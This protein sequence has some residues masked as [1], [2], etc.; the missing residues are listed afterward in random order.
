MRELNALQLQ[1]THANRKSPSKSR[2][3]LHQ[4]D[5]RCCKCSQHNQI[6]NFICSTFLCLVVLW[7]F[8]ACVLSNWW[9]C[10]L[11]LQ[12]F[13]FSICSVFLYLIV[14]WAFA[15]CVVS[16]WGSCFLNL[17]VF[18]SICS[19]LSSL[20]HRK[21]ISN[22]TPLEFQK[23]SQTMLRSLQSSLISKGTQTG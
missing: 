14:L 9:S 5:S 2:K 17:Q 22:M 7:A 19:A 16:N 23:R 20:D 12:V 15:G 1:K 13:F 21:E 6:K 4:F 11:N 10:F 18:F 3:H 8:V